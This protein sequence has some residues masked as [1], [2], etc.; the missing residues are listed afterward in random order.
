MKVCC[1]NHVV[2]IKLLVRHRNEKYRESVPYQRCATHRTGMILR[3]GFK[4]PSSKLAS[5]KPTTQHQKT[6]KCLIPVRIRPQNW[7]RFSDSRRVRDQSLELKH[8]DQ[9]GT[10]RSFLAS[11][12]DRCRQPSPTIQL[13]TG[14]IHTGSPAAWKAP[15]QTRAGTG[16]SAWRRAARP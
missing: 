14:R 12:N 7:E 3:N 2:D 9:N 15:R 10:T 11:R 5:K 8:R 1:V 16:P 13:Q 6:A 4:A